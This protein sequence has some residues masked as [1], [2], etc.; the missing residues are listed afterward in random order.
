[1]T[2]ANAFPAV[3]LIPIGASGALGWSPTPL[4]VTVWGLPAASLLMAIVPVRVPATVGTKVTKR[5]QLLPLPKLLPQ[6][7]VNAKSPFA[8]LPAKLSVAFPLLVTSPAGD[9]FLG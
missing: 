4:S 7:F 6:L 3:A 8:E 9:P 1:M 5:L 2:D